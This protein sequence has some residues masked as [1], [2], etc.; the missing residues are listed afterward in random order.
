MAAF[1]FGKSVIHGKGIFAARP[2]AHNVNLGV[3]LRRKPWSHIL[4]F[5]NGR[6]P[7]NNS[8]D[9]IIFELSWTQ[10]KFGKFLNHRSA[11][12]HK[13]NNCANIVPFLLPA[14]NQDC[15]QNI[16]TI[17]VR[18]RVKVDAGEELLLD[19]HEIEVLLNQCDPGV[20]YLCPF[21]WFE[22]NLD[23]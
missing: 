22:S 23:L 17:F 5:L 4:S 20:R 16:D 13:E 12:S 21:T 3:V 19:Y 11:F 14:N 2:L 9:P 7:W 8:D 6:L 18:T 10:T 1:Y 15:E